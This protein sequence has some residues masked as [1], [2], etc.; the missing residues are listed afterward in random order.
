MNEFRNIVVRGMNWLGDAVMTIPAVRALREIFPGAAVTMLA[1]DNLAPL[2]ENEPAVSGVIPFGR[3]PSARRKAAL[4]RR[5]RAG[6]FDLGVLFPN[7]FESAL[8]LLLGGVRVRLGYP[9]CGRRLLLNR[10]VAERRGRGRHQVHRSMDLA[11]ALGPVTVEPVPSVAVPAPAARRAD[12]LL[13]AG[14]IGT[15]EPLLGINPGATY[16][17]AKCWPPDRFA[18]LAALA[19]DRLGLR[20]AIVGGADERTLA[21]EIRAAAGGGAVNLAGGTTIMDLAAVA[22][23]CAVFVSNDTGPMHLAAAVGTPVVAVVGPTDPA[24]TGPLGRAVVVRGEADCAPCR[25][26]ECP[27]DHRCMTRITVEEVFAA[28]AGMAGGAGA[29]EGRR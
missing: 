5:L 2:W 4:I 20:A 6:R 24:E 12:E 18:R 23:R 27:T 25:R 14:G 16:G 8:W 7:S 1:P 13:R 17:S 28:T 26:R 11:R 3:P 9:T 19:R 21:E 29:A 15:G 10:P 22:R